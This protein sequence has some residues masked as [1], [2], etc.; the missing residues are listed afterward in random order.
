MLSVEHEDGWFFE[1]LYFFDD[2]RRIIEK[3]ILHYL[4]SH[5]KKDLK[6]FKRKTM[7]QRKQ[8]KTT[9]KCTRRKNIRFD[10]LIGQIA[11]IIF[12]FSPNQG[13]NISVLLTSKQIIRG[14]KIYRKEKLNVTLIEE[15]NDQCVDLRGNSRYISLVPKIS[16][17]TLP[18]LYQIREFQVK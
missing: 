4:L 15:Q 16:D 9:W 10:F 8:R 3:N 17:S 7:K 12:F 14:E 6:L 13:R 1:K 11:K 5:V 18:I 2:A